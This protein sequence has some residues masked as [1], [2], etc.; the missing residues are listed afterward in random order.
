M[1]TV[2]SAAVVILS[3][4]GLK[5]ARSTTAKASDKVTAS[6]VPKLAIKA[7]MKDVGVAVA[8]T[9]ASA[10]LASNAMAIEEKR[11]CSRTTVLPTQ[12]C[13][14]RERNPVGVDASKI[15]MSEEVS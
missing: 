13:V 6:T 4:T 7:S 12:R 3:F 14:R 2:T 15:S 5:A 9:A 11:L 1:A 10:I 8:A